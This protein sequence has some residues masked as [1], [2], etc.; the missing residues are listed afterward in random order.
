[1]ALWDLEANCLKHQSVGRS[2]DN[3]RNVILQTTRF[4]NRWGFTE[5]AKKATFRNRYIYVKC[6][7]YNL[8]Y[9]VV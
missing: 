5:F 6:V 9:F 3:V 7:T 8:T 1:M 2:N 4:K